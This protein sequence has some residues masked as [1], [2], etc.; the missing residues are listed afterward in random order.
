MPDHVVNRALPVIALDGADLPAVAAE[1]R[2]ACTG[3]GFFYLRG[4]GVAVGSRFE[5]GI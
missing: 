4:H 3:P 1:I 2:A 5:D